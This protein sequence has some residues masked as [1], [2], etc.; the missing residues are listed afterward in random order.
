MRN[1]VSRYE[2]GTN[3]ISDRPGISENVYFQALKKV[4]EVTIFFWIIKLLTT[5]MGETTSDFMVTHIDPVIAVAIGG[6][7]FVAALIL[8]FAVRRYI[9]WVYWLAAAMVAVFGTMAA[10]VLHIVFHVPYLVS[11]SFFLVALIAIFAVWYMIEKTLSI[12]SIYTRRRELFYWAAVITTFA[13]GTATGDMT[14]STMHLGYFASGVLFAV[15]ISLPAL[16]YFLLGMNEILAFWIA[17]ILTR[18]LGASFADWLGKPRDFSGFGLGTGW[19]S[20]V[21]AVLIVGFVAYVTVTRKD[22]DKAQP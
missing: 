14:A 18:P 21:L 1:P 17:Y 20:L 2:S 13:L 8:Q 5:A 16:A 15:L 9:P 11:A 4:P 7:G 19:V 22:V 10:D 3:S 12:H 6:V